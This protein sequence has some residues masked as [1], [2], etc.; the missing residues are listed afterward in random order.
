MHRSLLASALLLA[1]LLAACAW[2]GSPTDAPTPSEPP[3]SDRPAPSGRTFHTAPPSAA[4]LVGEVPAEVMD[5]ILAAAAERAGVAREELEVI[6]AE[7]VTWS[8]GSLGCPEPG[9]MY[10]QAL[11]DGYHVVIVAG[12]DEL[13]YRVGSAGS[14]RVCESP[15]PRGG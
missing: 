9:Q 8:D 4:A 6:R 13:D 12:D 1:V 7:Q 10:T 14:F 15:L 2:T 11:V 5:P 3:A